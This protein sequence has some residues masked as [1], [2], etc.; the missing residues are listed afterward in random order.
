MTA[1]A[2]GLGSGRLYPD[3]MT[4]SSAAAGV[5]L[6]PDYAGPCVTNLVPALLA[7][8]DIGQGWIP[9]E[10]LDARRVVLLVLDGLGAEQL[11]DRREHAPTLHTMT[12]GRIVTVAPSTTSSALTSIATGVPPG[13]HGIVGYKLWTGGEVVNT[14]RW[15]S[16]R[17]D[18]SDRV[19]PLD[20]QPVEPFLGTAPPVVSAREFATS[21][22]TAAHLRGSAYRGFA[23]PSSLP[24]EVRAALDGGARFVYAY[25]DG[26]DK[27]AHITGLGAH[28]DAELGHVDRLV[29]ALLDALPAGVALVVSA[30]HGQVQV[31]DNLTQLAPEVLANTQVISGEP[32]FV[33]LHARGG[34]SGDL[35]AAALDH[36]GDHAWVRSVE[37]VLDERWLGDVTPPARARLGDVAVV[38][39]GDGA[40]VDGAS[41]GPLL[42]SRHGSLTPAEMVVPLHTA[43]V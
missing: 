43:V 25:Y 23:L 42:Q 14:L 26:I 17:G 5:P 4:S 2:V 30:D 36:H 40:L 33:W 10:V 6:I 7:H 34:R 39:C 41:P 28:Y 19:D 13:E 29:G 16:A 38:V 37:Q 31:G 11:A 1:K 24:V 8:R 35:L 22:F 32:R 21:S 18:V 12:P 20:I 3:A 9:D 15:S 27:V